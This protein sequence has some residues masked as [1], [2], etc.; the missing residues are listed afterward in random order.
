VRKNRRKKER[1]HRA[2]IHRAAIKKFVKFGCVVC[3][4]CQRANMHTLM[5]ILHTPI[6]EAN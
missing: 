4:V 2:K 1:N 5:A 6:P 3:K